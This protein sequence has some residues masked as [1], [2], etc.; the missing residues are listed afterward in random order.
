MSC[1]DALI[2]NV[3]TITTKATVDE[4]I[5][6]IVECEIRAVPI[7]DDNKK[8]LGL[9]GLHSLMDDLLPV[10]ARLE[11]GVEDLGFVVDGA[12]GA[13]KRI[14]KLGPQLAIKHV[15]ELDAHKVLTPDVHMLEAIRRLSKYG[16]PLPVVDQDGKFVG[17]V[18]EQSCL[19]HLR[20][21]LQVVE[22]EEKKS[23]TL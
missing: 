12:P 20:N 9:F 19:S 8:F 2:P 3:I 21:V 18:S 22:A 14:R 5:R 15:E 13:A 1:M 10:A 17:L 11:D 6:L 16:S 4:A 23:G 7:L